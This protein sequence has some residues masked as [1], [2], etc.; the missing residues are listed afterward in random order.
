MRSRQQSPAV[1]S[2][3]VAACSAL[4]NGAEKIVPPPL[5]HVEAAE[6]ALARLADFREL[7]GNADEILTSEQIRKF[8]AERGFQDRRDPFAFDSVTS[9]HTGWGSGVVDNGDTGKSKGI[10][11]VRKD[12]RPF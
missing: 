1:E 8:K 10:K 12:G 7:M 9:G 3:V 5:Y 11:L 4:G 2:L 6:A